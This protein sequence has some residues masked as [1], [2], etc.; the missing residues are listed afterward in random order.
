[1]QRILQDGNERQAGGR[2]RAGVGGFRLLLAAAASVLLSSSVLAQGYPMGGGMPGSRGGMGA[3]SGPPMDD[4]AQ[5]KTPEKSEKEAKKYFTAGMKSLNKARGY[6]DELAKAPNEDK[7][8]SLRDKADDAY[9]RALDQF[10]EA[11]RNDNTMVDAWTNVGYA[12]LKL[13]AYNES[14]DV[15]SH[16]L[17]VKPDLEEVVE[18]RAEGYVALDRLDDAKAAYME[19]YNHSRPL[20]D[21]LMVKMHAWLEG[22]R[23][24]P[25]GMRA[26]DIDAFGKWLAERDGIAKQSAS[27]GS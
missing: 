25:N 7:R 23:A 17:G 26:G 15:Y 1:M 2:K 22:H 10:T 3:P 13:G 9:N 18:R 19:L 21:E 27:A 6:E 14:V 5:P 11:V 8:A 12:Q 16:V 20:A 24:A 4:T